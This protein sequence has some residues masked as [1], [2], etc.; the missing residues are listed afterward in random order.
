MYSVAIFVPMVTLDM[1]AL[2]EVKTGSGLALLF[3]LN[4]AE[5]I[6]PWCPIGRWIWMSFAYFTLVVKQ[7]PSPFDIC[8]FAT[9]REVQPHVSVPEGLW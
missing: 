7:M 4:I 8:H 6:G 5:N 3:S 1:T 2:V 9:Y